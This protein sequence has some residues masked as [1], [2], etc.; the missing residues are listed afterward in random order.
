MNPHLQSIVTGNEVPF[1]YRI[2]YLGNFFT[3]PISS[4]NTGSRRPSM[5]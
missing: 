4:A 2:R 3:G 5:S 1:G